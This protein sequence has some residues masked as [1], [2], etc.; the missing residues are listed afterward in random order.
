MN[1]KKL[2]GLLLVLL[3]SVSF[4][5]CSGGNTD[6]GK[7]KGEYKLEAEGMAHALVVAA[8]EKL[9]TEYSRSRNCTEDAQIENEKELV[10]YCHTGHIGRSHRAYH[11][12]VKHIYKVGYAV[13]HHYWQHQYHYLLVKSSVAYQIFQQVFSPFD[14]IKPF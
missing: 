9:S 7:D 1:M 5:A 10:G 8:A 11:N 2:L 12:V 4:T 13:L 3:M 14:I 6:G